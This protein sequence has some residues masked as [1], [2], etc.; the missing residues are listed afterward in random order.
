LRDRLRGIYRREWLRANV[1][2]ERTKAVATVLREAGL[3]ALFVEG[4]V[5][6]ARY[7][8]ALGLRPSWYVDVLA[9]ENDAPRAL[10]AL[11]DAG[12]SAPDGDAPTGRWAVA[13]RDRIVCVVRTSVAY[14]FVLRNDP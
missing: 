10:A 12:W 1:L 4:A 14:D 3:E 9:R 6:A 8:P 13:D 5:V 7:Y 11:A 2:A